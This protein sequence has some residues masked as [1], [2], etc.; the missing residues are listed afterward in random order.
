MYILIAYIHEKQDDMF[1]IWR[2][3]EYCVGYINIALLL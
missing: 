2:G 1:I 3:M